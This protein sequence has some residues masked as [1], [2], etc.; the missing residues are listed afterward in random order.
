ML[1]KEKQ[2]QQI[3]SKLQLNSNVYFEILIP[4]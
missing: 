2:T 3:T 4:R 1:K